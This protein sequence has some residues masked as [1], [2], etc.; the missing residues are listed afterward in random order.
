MGTPGDIGPP[1][2]RR[3]TA[4][5]DPGPEET[6]RLGQLGGWLFLAGSLFSFP[7]GLLLEPMPAASSHL[8]GIAGMITAVACLFAPWQRLSPNWLHLL[9][10]FGTLQIALAVRIF[11]DDFAF[12]YV[13][14]AAY[15]AYLVRDRRVLGAYFGLFTLA[16]LAPLVYDG[17]NAREQAHHITVILPVL[18]IVGTLVTY[19]R[20]TL[21]ARE[22]RYRRFALE[23]VTLA[24]RL[25][26]TPRKREGSERDALDVRLDALAARADDEIPLPEKVPNS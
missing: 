9:L 1:V 5:G 4:F 10:L 7:A 12:Y 21:E 26:G 17:D 2:E 25:R 20:E 11:S 3:A 13:L 8:L 24:G 15:A 18:L 16:L 23:A 19:L 14:V 6:R 22:R